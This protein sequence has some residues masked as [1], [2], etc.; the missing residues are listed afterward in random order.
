MGGYS[1]APSVPPTP[2]LGGGASLSR[3][4]S[5]PA[6]LALPNAPTRTF[7]PSA[8]FPPPR[9]F[10][11]GQVMGRKKLAGWDYK[12]MATSA[13]LGAA[14][15]A[16]QAGGAGPVDQDPSAEGP[17]LLDLPDELI[18]RI[19][20]DVG[21]DP[22]FGIVARHKLPLGIICLN[23]RIFRLALPLSYRSLSFPDTTELQER[24]DG[25]YAWLLRTPHQRRHTRHV[26]FEHDPD[27]PVLQRA[28]VATFTH[29][30]SLSFGVRSRPLH[31]Q[32][33]CDL[34]C[35][36]PSLE[37]LDLDDQRRADDPPL[38]LVGFR[39]LRDSSIQRL[40]VQT[41]SDATALLGAVGTRRLQQLEV[42]HRSYSPH[43]AEVSPL[44]WISSERVNYQHFL[45]V[46]AV[47][48]IVD[49]LKHSDVLPHVRPVKFLGLSVDNSNSLDPPFEAAPSSW[50][51]TA[52]EQLLNILQPR[53]LRL[54]QMGVFPRVSRS[55]GSSL[56]ATECLEL[57]AYHTIESSRD[58][59]R[60][61]AFLNL[62]PSLTHLTLA[63]VD[64]QPDEA[65]GN[66]TVDYCTLDRTSFTLRHPFL[67]AFFVYL[68]QT[69]ILS[70]RFRAGARALVCWRATATED[71]EADMITL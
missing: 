34:I 51:W 28:F 2:S 42:R 61:H 29:L 10:D 68:R 30:Q 66:P 21:F 19:F 40:T 71:F 12:T 63:H 31:E 6:V 46:D 54:D 64:F 20:E 37:E 45:T 69:R 58:L 67:A 18:A 36:L 52:L 7:P 49:N 9:P 11:A 1:A 50:Y 14:D 60:L 33:L 38:S 57:I 13:D 16:I 62:F 65:C 43:D 24:I 8:Q 44:P 27:H 35:A 70:A 32:H 39:L 48:A 15:D 55:A 3:I 41:L 4:P 23:K 25:F 5:P 47:N 22:E 26:R 59:L 17:S 56:M 53:H